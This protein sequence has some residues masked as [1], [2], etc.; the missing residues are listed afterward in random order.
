MRQLNLNSIKAKAD[1]DFKNITPGAYACIITEVKDNENKEYLDALFDIQVGEFDGYY[2][3]DFYKDKPW[4][5]HMILSYKENALP[6]FKGRMET[7]T[8]CNTG[9]DAV[10]A[11][12]AGQY[13][14]LEGKVV[15]IVFREEEYFDKKTSEFKLGGARAFRFC[16]TEDIQEGKNASPKPKML[17]HKGKIDALRRAGVASNEDDAEDWLAEYE[18]DNAAS[19]LAPLNPTSATIVQPDDIPF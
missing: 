9:F 4:A 8:K 19:T 3:S 18:N 11:L 17:D 5:H 7:I 16:T 1:G 15:G 10:A 13:K 6:I 12:D 14:M 2:S